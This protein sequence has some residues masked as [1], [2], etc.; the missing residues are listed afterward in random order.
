VYTEIRRPHEYDKDDVFQ[1]F[2]GD[3]V[4]KSAPVCQAKE[5]GGLLLGSIGNMPSS[6]LEAIMT[7][8]ET[9]GLE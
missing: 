1:S 4:S 8:P 2:I 3:L 6:V 5:H 7:L 9:M